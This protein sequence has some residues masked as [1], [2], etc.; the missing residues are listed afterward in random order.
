MRTT[1]LVIILF[2]A[3]W[4]QSQSQVT[5]KDLPGTNWRIIPGMSNKNALLRQRLNNLDDRE[6]FSG[7]FNSGRLSLSPTEQVVMLS[8]G[9]KEYAVAKINEDLKFDWATSIPGPL[10]TIGKVNNKIIV[11]YGNNPVDQNPKTPV[12]AIVLDASTGK[13]ITG[14]T[15]FD[16]DPAKRSE[17]KVFFVP[18]SN[19]FYFG[20][21]YTDADTKLRVFGGKENYD[22]ISMTSKFELIAYDEN[23]DQLSKK[24]VPMRNKSN[25][26]SVEMTAAKELFTIYKEDDGGYFVQRTAANHTE[27]K[28]FKRINLDLAK[29]LPVKM[30]FVLSGNDQNVCYLTFR[31]FNSDK[32][33]AVTLYR[34][35]F[36]TGLMKYRTDSYTKAHRKGIEENH[37]PTYEKP[38]KLR[39]ADWESMEYTGLIE[40]G[41]KLI[42]L[43]E[44]V[45]E[46]VPMSNLSSSQ[47]P[48]KSTTKTGDGILS[49]LDSNLKLL[50]E[51]P[52]AKSV[53][54]NGIE[55]AASGFMLRGNR[56]F[57]VTPENEGT[58]ITIVIFEYDLD[59][60]QFIRRFTPDK[61]QIKKKHD[62]VPAA[63][64]WFD[65]SYAI[66]AQTD[67]GYYETSERLL[68]V[69]F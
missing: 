11:I 1:L 55:H 38:G 10:M 64:L 24:E 69:Q 60:K 35:D 56:V 3:L 68:K 46:D 6:K 9:D 49:I 66:P 15:L 31:Y 29:N 17:V 8:V 23:L 34:I 14:K 53:T 52:F 59:K 37:S 13:K 21:R 63:T 32:D 45:V 47:P 2:F 30:D 41:N 57:I 28:E 54:V 26:L 61:G 51:V 4:Q 36:G 27:L 58:H 33:W 67:K 18:K 48:S 65:K 40:Q 19:E 12:H 7:N 39:T 16:R 5:A 22:L 44:A 20:I 62:L 25:F 50:Q 42:C 43:K